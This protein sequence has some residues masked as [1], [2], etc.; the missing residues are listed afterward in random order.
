M[1]KQRGRGLGR[2]LVATA[3]LRLPGPLFWG[4]VGSRGAGL[5]C[6]ADLGLNP[7]FTATD[8]VSLSEFSFAHLGLGSVIYKVSIAISPPQCCHESMKYVCEECDRMP[9]V[10]KHPQTGNHLFPSILVSGWLP[11]FIWL[12]SIKM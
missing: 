10:S 3:F 1:E 2:C 5:W 4:G 12:E 11:Q 9:S 6:W 7:R 8:S